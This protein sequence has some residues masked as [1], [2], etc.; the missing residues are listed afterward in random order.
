MK[1]DVFCFSSL[2]QHPTGEI[3]GIY[4]EFDPNTQAALKP[5]LKDFL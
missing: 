5:A 4:Q 3:Q 2:Q 1:D